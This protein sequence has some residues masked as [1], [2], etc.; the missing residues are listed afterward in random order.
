[1]A[2]QPHGWFNEVVLNLFGDLGNLH[3]WLVRHFCKRLFFS[4]LA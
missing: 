3:S 2:I 4:S 1:M